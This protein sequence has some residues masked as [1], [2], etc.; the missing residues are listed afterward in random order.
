MKTFLPRL[1]FGCICASLLLIGC[2]QP[3]SKENIRISFSKSEPIYPGAK[4]RIQ[5]TNPLI[6]ESLRVSYQGQELKINNDTIYLPTALPLGRHRFVAAYTHQNQTHET[7]IE[8]SVY[9][10]KPPTKIK[11]K[12]I[13]TYD[14]STA[15]YTQGLEFYGD[16]LIESTGGLSTS[17]I[18][19]YDPFSGE[20]FKRLNLADAIFGEGITRIGDK[21][22]HLTWKNGYG[23]IR[24]FKDL[25][26]LASF[27]YQSSIEGWGLTHDEQFIYKSDGT[28]YLWKLDKVTGSELS[29]I[30]IG[31][32][33]AYFKNANELEW[34]ENL[35]FANVYQKDGVMIIDPN[36]GA[37]VGVVDLGFLKDLIDKNA[38]FDPL[39][40]VLNGIAYHPERGTF[41]VTGKN[42]NKLFE[43]Q[44]DLEPI[45]KALTKS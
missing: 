37:I 5:A 13:A 32:Q 26:S 15:N 43:L 44:I 19:V 17:S 25:D 9:A 30:T 39:N 29:Y 36:T 6:L 24:S 35:I 12:L 14:H 21:L 28:E 27:Q 41:F 23:S 42:W 45:K 38:N 18:L 8:L 16:L 20:E 3:N 11:A 7:P 33:N 31:T 1:C 40:S 2:N 10:K 22:F 4:V 34:A